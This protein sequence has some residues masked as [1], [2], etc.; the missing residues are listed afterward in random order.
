MPNGQPRRSLDASKAEALF[1]FRAKVR[2]ERGSS[3]RS[4][5]IAP[6]T[7]W[8]RRPIAVGQWPAARSS[9][10]AEVA[11]EP[12]GIGRLS[13]EATF[14]V[15][16]VVA[17]WIAVGLLATAAAHNGWLYYQGGDQ[18]FF[19]TIAWIV[20]HG[21]LPVTGIG[22]AWS[23]VEAP[24]AAVAGPSFLDALPGIIAIQVVLLLP[25]GLVAF[26]GTPS[27][28]SVRPWRGSG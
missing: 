23:L 19:Y 4:P 10:D 28:C 14:L 27:G 2:C 17:Q 6:S 25:L 18:T 1:G 8:R 3:A 7:P 16:A 11:A 13:G 26:Y 5:G 21:H 15:G 24:V 12:S 20:S 22:Y 9:R